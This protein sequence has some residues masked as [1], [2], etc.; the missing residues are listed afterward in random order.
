MFF[1][2]IIVMAVRSLKQNLMRSVLATLGVIIGVGAVVSA[3]SILEGAQRDIL[4]RFETLGAD[5]VLVFNGSDQHAHRRTQK[6]SLI[7]RDANTIAE[8]SPD[9]IIATAPQYNGGGQIKYF[10]RNAY[11]AVLGTTAAYAEINNYKVVQGRF[12]TREDVRGSSMVAVLGHT[13]AQDL[14]GALPGVGKSIKINGKTFIVVGIMEEKGA[15]GFLEVDRQVNI[16]LTT[17]MGRMFG[18]RYLSMLV[19]QCVDAQRVPACIERIKKSLRQT[20]RIKAGDGDD[21]IVFT[22]EQFKQQLGM[23]AKIFAVVL[24]SIAGISLI[25][26]AIGIM[27]IM[28]V[29]VTERTREIGVRIAVGARRFDILRQFLTEAS[30]ISLIGG[31]CGVICGWAI[32]NFLGDF[33][34]VLEVY[35]PPISIVIALVMATVVGVLSGIYPA[36]RAARLDPVTALRYE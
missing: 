1:F 32:A 14:F 24:Y 19:T 27:N 4:E 10:E 20:H 2:R 26:G 15:L 33:T 13:L 29:S 8:D 34:Q 17:A 6:M 30:I 35:T 3:V 36:V 31:G 7:P 5:Q 28:L 22:Q 21:F 18:S 11:G 25:V 16:P 12:L 23:V 9:L